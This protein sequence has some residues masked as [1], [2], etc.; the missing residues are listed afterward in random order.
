MNNHLQGIDTVIVRVKDIDH[1]RNWYV[2]NLGL[3]PE[4]DDPVLKLVVLNTGGPTSLTIWQTDSPVI[5]SKEGSSYPIFR[6]P[7]AKHA[8]M[9][10]EARQVKTDPIITDHAVTYFRFYDPDGNIMEACQIH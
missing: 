8:Q 7:N 5:S 3:S 6:T 4:W 9:A 10:L 2:E 1:S